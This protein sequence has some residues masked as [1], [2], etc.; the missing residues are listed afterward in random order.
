MTAAAD[1]AAA[2]VFIVA[3]ATTGRV[4]AADP[5]AGARVIVRGVDLVLGVAA[6]VGL[7]NKRQI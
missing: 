1:V 7:N 6:L 2:R 4:A 3:V 5:A